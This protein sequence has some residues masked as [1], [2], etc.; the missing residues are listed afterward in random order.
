MST[1]I[2]NA[3]LEQKSFIN[4]CLGR[5]AAHAAVL[6]TSILFSDPTLG[7]IVIDPGTAG[8]TFT[9]K[10]YNVTSAMRAAGVTNANGTRVVLD[11]IFSELKGLQ[12]NG[13]GVAITAKLDTDWRTNPSG[14]G[15]GYSLL[16][17]SAELVA[18]TYQGPGFLGDANPEVEQPNNFSPPHLYDVTGSVP[19]NSFATYE[20]VFDGMRFAFRLPY[21]ANLGF[22]ADVPEEELVLSN[23]TITFSSEPRPTGIPGVFATS[24]YTVVNV[25]EPS[26]LWV[27]GTTT[28]GLVAK[29]RRRGDSSRR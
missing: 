24:T 18:W 22:P 5:R 23:A 25:P 11:F 4:G 19:T 3:D 1:N 28:L 26:V 29:R 7:A 6:L 21:S 15:R 8:E 27:L 14:I 13:D 10:S 2:R 16:A 12:V 17:G 20:P 9:S